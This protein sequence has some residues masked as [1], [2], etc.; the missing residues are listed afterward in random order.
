MAAIARGGF[1]KQP[2]LFLEGHKEPAD[3]ENQE[4]SVYLNISPQTLAVIY[5]GMSAVVNESG[6]TAYTEFVDVLAGLTEQGIKVYGKTG[7]TEAPE[8]AW[9]AGFVTGGAGGS[10]AIAVVIEGGQ[11]GSSDA[12]PLARDIIQF[13]IGEGYV[14]QTAQTQE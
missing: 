8:N 1:Y 11:R 4:S 12:A 7:S 6:G 3:N 14:G 2:R 5:D 10:I 9:F 13:C